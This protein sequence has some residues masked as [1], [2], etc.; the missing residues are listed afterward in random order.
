ALVLAHVLA[1]KDRESTHEPESLTEASL[2]LWRVNVTS[3]RRI[4]ATTPFGAGG[5]SG[6]ASS[7]S[8]LAFGTK[9]LCPAH[10]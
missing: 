6:G 9:L 5:S 2:G 1:R 10:A 4:N 7:S 3:A 8:G